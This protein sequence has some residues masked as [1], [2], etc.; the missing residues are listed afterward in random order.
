MVFDA[1]W[2]GGAIVEIRWSWRWFVRILGAEGGPKVAEDGGFAWERGGGYGGGETG[3]KG[4]VTGLKLG[5]RWLQGT[6]T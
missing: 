6:L 5:N 1:G 4:L 3:W 2:L